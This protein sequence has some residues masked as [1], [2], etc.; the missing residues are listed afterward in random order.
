LY[1]HWF[2]GANSSNSNRSQFLDEA[3]SLAG[4]GA[5]A[6]LVDDIYAVP[7]PRRDWGCSQADEDRQ[8]V[9]QQVIELR[10]A[11]DLLLTE[12]NADPER[13]A[14]VGHDFG[15]MFVLVLAGVDP[16]IKAVVA[17]TAASDFSD[18]FLIRGAVFVG[19]ARRE[20]CAQ[21]AP[22]APIQYVGNGVT[23]FDLFLQFANDDPFTPQTDATALFDAAAEPKR[24]EWYS[25]G[26]G[27]HQIATQ[28]RVDWL[29]TELGME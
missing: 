7:N 6:L 10:R 22:V 21:L 13:I 23:S 19:D 15:G 1:V 3:V 12:G 9:I 20:Y 25:G 11:L 28:D 17:M 29:R 5:V 16:R 27:L 26:H 18:W 4:Q 24:I 14:V 2:G 8:E